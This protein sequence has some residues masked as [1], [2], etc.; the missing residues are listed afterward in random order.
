MELMTS[1]FLDIC[2]TYVISPQAEKVHKRL[3]KFK[4][5]YCGKHSKKLSCVL[6]QTYQNPSSHLQKYT[7]FKSPVYLPMLYDPV[8]QRSRA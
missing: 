3:T 2:L 8:P 1:G 7:V 4:R 5:S 6:Y